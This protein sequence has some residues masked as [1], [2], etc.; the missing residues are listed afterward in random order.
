MA[1]KSV[2]RTESARDNQVQGT[3]YLY[4][5]IKFN[6]PNVQTTAGK[7]VYVGVLPQNS[8]KMHTIV[9]INTTFNKDLIIGTSSN[10]A[11]FGSTEDIVAGTAETYVIDKGFGVT[12]TAADVPVYVQLTTGGTVGEADVWLTYIKAN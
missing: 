2:L 5:R 7:I 11:A 9:R 3:Q 6:T 4:K 8:C 12:T 1:L 10:T